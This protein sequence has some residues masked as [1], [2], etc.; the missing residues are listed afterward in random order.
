MFSAAVAGIVKA[1]YLG[2]LTSHSDLTCK[3]NPPIQSFIFISSLGETYNLAVWSG[4][5]I[6][7]TIVCGSMP[8]LKPLWDHYVT[9]QRTLPPSCCQIATGRAR[10]YNLNRLDIAKPSSWYKFSRLYSETGK[11]NS[12]ARHMRLDDV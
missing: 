10:A 5:E 9:K 4:A 1:N 8:P 3:S 11:H 12:E 2:G 6:F 7:V